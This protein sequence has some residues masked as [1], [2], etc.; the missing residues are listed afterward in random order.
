MVAALNCWWPDE[1]IFRSLDG[2][3]TWSPIWAWNSYPSEYLY[4]TYDVSNAPWLIDSTDTDAFVSKIGWMVEA[5]V[6]DP[7]DSN[8]W[9]YGTGETIYGSHDLLKWDT[10]HNVTLKSLAVGIEETAVRGLISPPGGP[11]LLSVHG[12]VGGFY[13]SSLTVSPSASFHNPTYGTTDDIDYAG[14]T[15]A[16]IVRSGESD[17]AISVS[18]SSDF[19]KTWSQYYGAST[20]TAPSNVAYSANGDTILLSSTANGTL[21]SRYSATFSAV[22]SL[23]AGAAIASDKRNNSYFYGG[24]GNAFYVSSDIGVTFTKTATLGTSTSVSKIRVHPSVAGDVWVTTDAGFFHSIDFGSTFTQ[25]SSGSVVAGYSFDLGAPSAT[26]GYPVIYGFF[27]I[28]SVV[29]LYKT[30]DKGTNWYLIS[31][32]THGF[33]AGSANVVG[34]DISNYGK[35]YV[36]TNGRGIFY[37]TPSGTLPVGTAT[38]TTAVVSSTTTSAVSS[39]LV[40]STKGSTTAV[41]SPTSSSSTKV[42][43]SNTSKSSATVTSATSSS[44]ATGT[45]SAYGQC[46]GSGWT[47]PTACPTGW[48]CTYSNAYYSQ[49]LQ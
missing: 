35:V 38:A 28:N 45:A 44:T 32:A 12:D 26:G 4:Y 1:Q 7:F 20:S 47:G 33:G 48:T 2:G 11:A 46:G 9:L 15:P 18:T 14:N 29:A 24:S 19:G 5:L 13:H 34:A 36:G 43:T 17:T 39:T 23:P 16:D 21:V 31:D 40:T 42:T 41:V 8:H 37:G 10:V 3:S 22:S 30:E 27:N 49:C 6:I 25:I